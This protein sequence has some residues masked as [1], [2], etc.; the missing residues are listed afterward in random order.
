MLT[1]LRKKISL[2][3]FHE[4]FKT[5]SRRFPLTL[6]S[7]F[8]MF[9]ISTAL[10]AGAE[11]FVLAR[12]LFTLI[13]V[14]LLSYAAALWIESKSVPNKTHTVI[15]YIAVFMLG[16]LYYFFIPE[17]L[18]GVPLEVGFTLMMILFLVFISVFCARFVVRYFSRSY[19]EEPFYLFTITQVVSMLVGVLVALIVF[20]LGAATLGSLDALFNIDIDGDLYFHWWV[21]AATLVGPLYFLSQ[22][23]EKVDEEEL[24]LQSLG[25]FLKLIILYAALP[26]IGIY[27]VILYAYSI[28][29]ITNFSQWPEGVVSWLVIFFSFFG[30]IT[31][32]LS[33]HVREEK[34]VMFFRRWFPYVLL[35]QAVMLFYA[36]WLRIEQHGFTVNRYLVVAFGVWI[37]FLC[38]YFIFSSKKKLFIIP[39]SLCVALV[40]VLVGPWGVFATSERSQTEKLTTLFVTYKIASAEGVEKLTPEEL[41]NI[42]QVDQD[43]MSSTMRY[44][45]E[46]HGCRTLQPLFGGAYDDIVDE[47]SNYRGASLLLEHIGLPTYVSSWT[48]LGDTEYKSW[49]AQSTGFTMNTADTESVTHLRSYSSVDQQ[50]MIKA[51]NR[52]ILHY[53]DSGVDTQVDITTQL[54]DVILTNS[55]QNDGFSERYTP[56]LITFVG[57]TFYLVGINAT[58]K[59]Q[60]VDQFTNIEGYLLVDVK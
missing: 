31:Y 2:K 51:D 14:S 11:E 7:L 43:N 56:T 59:N 8:A 15:T 5:L 48:S 52:V 4:I 20:L 26:F 25:K 23:P 18:G 12:T 46:N 27:F 47:S 9:A 35:P 44:I 29:V 54:T 21:F 37:T 33:H 42:P 1:L 57:G 16:L 60:V 40:L 38:L 41:E 53:V 49:Y 34:V 19:T 45:C 10:I 22:I 36:I 28:Q 13:F 50:F 30:Y 3:S 32:F 39:A 24:R 17:D 55:N 58:V 6:V